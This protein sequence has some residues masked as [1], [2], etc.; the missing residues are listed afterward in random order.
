MSQA[1]FVRW[2]IYDYYEPL[3]TQTTQLARLAYMFSQ[4]NGGET[5][6]ELFTERRSFSS[7]E[8]DKISGQDLEAYL[9][10]MF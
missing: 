10:G 8:K 5:E 6:F 3:D 1:D 7:E 4:A 2:V 9:K